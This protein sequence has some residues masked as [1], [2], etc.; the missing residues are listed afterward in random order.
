MVLRRDDSQP[1]PCP[2][3]FLFGTASGQGTEGLC[4]SASRI[5]YRLVARWD[6]QAAW[7]SPEPQHRLLMNGVWFTAPTYRHSFGI[8][9]GENELSSFKICIHVQEGTVGGSRRSL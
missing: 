4:T 3:G 2:A 7:G 6:P 8:H 1:L 9:L 5:L